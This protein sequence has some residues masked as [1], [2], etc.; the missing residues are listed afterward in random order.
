MCNVQGTRKVSQS[1][2]NPGR[3][4]ITCTSCD[5]FLGWTDELKQNMEA[6]I[7]REIEEVKK[8]IRE[9]KMIMKMIEKGQSCNYV[10]N[11][12]YLSLYHYAC[13]NIVVVY[14]FFNVSL[15]RT[16]FCFE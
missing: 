6:K 1:T 14:G 4:Y 9:M 10:A 8:E 11:Y 13:L 3:V 7:L 5:K 15:A 2:T 16:G 12:S